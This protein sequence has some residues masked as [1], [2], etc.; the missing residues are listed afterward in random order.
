MQDIEVTRAIIDSYYKK[1][2]EHI[3][4]D[5]IFVGAGPAGMAGAY[6]L[7]K[8]GLKVTV[9]EKRLSVG[10]GI[11]GG[12]MCMNQ[13]VVQDEALKI[14]DDV[15]VRHEPYKGPLHTVDTVEMAA[16]LCLAA[17][18]ARAT[19]LNAMTVEDLAVKDGRAVGVVV[20]STPASGVFHVDPITLSGRAI[21]DS[22]GHEAAVVASLK[23]RQLLDKKL[24][25]PTAVE[26]PM[27]AE[28]GETFV[29]ENVCEVFP[30]LWLAGMS[31]CAILGGPRMGPIFGGMLMSGKRAAEMIAKDLGES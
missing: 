15:G 21:I 14:L 28:A 27:N 3:V 18:Q 17:I 25:A 24:M 5:V 12:G 19:I 29:V 4:S 13:A 11:W 31:V 30:G 2:T 9:I 23:K 7:A 20:N 6:Y 16:G 22:T 26:G 8:R 10:G 1:L